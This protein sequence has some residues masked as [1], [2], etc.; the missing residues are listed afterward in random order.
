MSSTKTGRRDDLLYRAARAVAYPTWIA[1]AVIGIG[2]AGG[3]IE[4]TVHV[5]AL[6]VLLAIAMPVGVKLSRMEL[7]K[8]MLAVFNAGAQMEAR[9][10]APIAKA[11]LLIAHV[12]GCPDC[13]QVEPGN[14][15]RYC[16]TGRRLIRETLEERHGV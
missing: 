12:D 1:A 15:K 7:T 2:L 8:A 5:V 14:S 16:P 3:L 9:R 13:G 4:G 10:H 6:V 11:D